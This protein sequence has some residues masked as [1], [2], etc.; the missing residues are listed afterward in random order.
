MME[1]KRFKAES[2]VTK[3]AIE[4]GGT[5]HDDMKIMNMQK[6]LTVEGLN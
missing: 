1:A 6:P 2:K 4:A 3:E 5:I